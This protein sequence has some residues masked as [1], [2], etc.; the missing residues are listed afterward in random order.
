MST[1]RKLDRP[2]RHCGGSLNG[3]RSDARF[4]NVN[5]RNAHF[6]RRMGR[7]EA[8]PAQ[9]IITKQE[10]EALI[11]AGHLEIQ[12]EHDPAKV[13]EAFYAMWDDFLS[14]YA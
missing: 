9:V 8:T 2:C 13:R 14:Q 1:G 12:D 3:K 5:C 4:C 7:V 6:K 11:E 10:R